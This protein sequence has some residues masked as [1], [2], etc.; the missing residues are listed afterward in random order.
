[1]FFLGAV[2][3][4]DHMLH[5][6]AMHDFG[7]LSGQGTPWKGR[8]LGLS[9]T[10]EWLQEWLTLIGMAL[11]QGSTSWGLKFSPTLLWAVVLPCLFLSGPTPL[12][13]PMLHAP[14]SRLGMV[15]TY[16]R[17]TLQPGTALC[18]A[19]PL[20]FPCSDDLNPVFHSY[21]VAVSLSVPA[22]CQM[23]HASYPVIWYPNLLI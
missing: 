5:V 4:L 17:R 6:M 21:E 1:M 20:I 3:R 15:S 11:G 19:T 8:G 7:V 10:S 9:C 12:R 23:V 14:C 13:V 2:T 22:H 16:T 18:W